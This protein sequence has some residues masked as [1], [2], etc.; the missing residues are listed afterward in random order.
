[1]LR[2]IDASACANRWRNQSEAVAVFCLGLMLVD[3]CTPALPGAILTLLAACVTAVCGPRIRLAAFARALL[4]P[5]GFI[6]LGSLSICVS[7]RRGNGF[8]IYF[9]QDGLLTVARVVL[10]A[11]SASAVLL[12]FAFTVS[13]TQLIRLLRMLHVSEALLD[14]V[15]LSY[16]SLFVLDERRRAIVSAQRN[17]L[18]Y[19]TSRLALRSAA[20]AAAALFI[21]SLLAAMRLERGLV[22]R[23]YNGRLVVLAAP[24]ETRPRHLAWAVALPSALG[25]C[26]FVMAWLWRS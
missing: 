10:R 1:M 11:W 4:M 18:G 16:R 19:R 7:V 22:A 5:L 15:H 2:T 24:S 6:A 8:P 9:E 17:R 14:L 23:G 12:L 21:E 13:V 25:L 26:A 3:F 20:Q